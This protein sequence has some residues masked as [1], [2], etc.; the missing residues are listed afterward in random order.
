[1]NCQD[2]DYP[3][4][5]P[6][7]NSIVTPNYFSNRWILDFWNDSPLSREVEQSLD[8]CERVNDK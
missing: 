1:M 6:I 8:G 2:I 7:N 4:S 5:Q 3:D